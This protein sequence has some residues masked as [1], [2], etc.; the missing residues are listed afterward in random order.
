MNISFIL[1]GEDIT[2][3]SE[4]NVRVIDILRQN[5]GLLGAKSG[6][7][8]GKCGC[9]AVIFNSKVSHACLIPA[10]MLQGSE[11]ITI[12][13]FSQTDEY[14]DIVNGFAQAKL[15]SCGFCETSKILSAGALLD[16]IKRPSR[17][18]IL[19][20]FSGIKCRCTDPDT[21]AL[22]IELAVEI[23]HRRLYGRSA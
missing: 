20:A 22:G 12:E 18:E 16:R 19:H 8:S 4:V 21:L 1:N 3:R 13:G 6:C 11:I 17:E 15:E 9:C 7:L 2:I 23:R 14:S 5:Y 10:F